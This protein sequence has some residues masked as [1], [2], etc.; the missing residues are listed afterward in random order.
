MF[1]NYGDQCGNVDNTCTNDVAFQ[2]D[3]LK[4]KEV[5]LS[6]QKQDSRCTVSLNCSDCKLTKTGDLTLTMKE[7]NSYATAI[8]VTISSSSSIPGEYSTIKTGVSTSDTTKYF[9]GAD[10]TIIYLLMTPSL[11]LTDA[12]DWD[13]ELQGYHVSEVSD[14]KK[15][16]EIEYSE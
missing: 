7:D 3:Y 11:F 16:S 13:N 4:G 10:P 15:G 9:R 12:R 1:D 8:H 14:P 6:C 2:T 5:K